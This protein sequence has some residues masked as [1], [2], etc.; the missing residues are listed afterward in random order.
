M[1]INLRQLARFAFSS[2]GLVST[3][4]LSYLY[5]SH[6]Y[7]FVSDYVN[8]FKAPDIFDVAAVFFMLAVYTAS[9]P[10]WCCGFSGGRCLGAQVTMEIGRPR[11][12]MNRTKPS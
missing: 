2:A 9:W 10:A 1:R 8:G 5:F 12:V 11:I 4:G 3:I 7:P 6:A